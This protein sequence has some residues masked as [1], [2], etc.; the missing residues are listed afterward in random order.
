MRSICVGILVCVLGACGPN[1]EAVREAIENANHCMVAEDCVNV[2]SICPFGCDI[3]VHE[4]EADAIESLI[5]DYL[6][7]QRSQCNYG[8]PATGSIVCEQQVC[9]TRGEVEG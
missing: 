6:D 4:S 2:G 3:V 5:N 8:C 7:H 9:A 1:A